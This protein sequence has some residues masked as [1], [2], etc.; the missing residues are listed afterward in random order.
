LYNAHTYA[1]TAGSACVCV[2]VCTALTVGLAMKDTHTH[3]QR[4]PAHYT[5]WFIHT[6]TC[7]EEGWI[8]AGGATSATRTRAYIVCTKVQHRYLFN[9]IQF[10]VN[11]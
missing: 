2:Y 4:D 1:H 3:T 8:G 5:I 6:Y 11:C 10:A 7:G 9:C